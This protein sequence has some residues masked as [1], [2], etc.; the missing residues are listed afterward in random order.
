MSLVRI[1]N[2]VFIH[3]QN[4]LFVVLEESENFGFRPG[5]K[6]AIS[7]PVPPPNIN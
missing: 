5:A 2:P 6:S 4:N 1:K 3:N 7:T